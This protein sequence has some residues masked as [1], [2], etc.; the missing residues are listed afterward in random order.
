MTAKEFLNRP[1][2]LNQRIKDK[3]ENAERLRQELYGRGI[4]YDNTSHSP[5]SS[6]DALG[7][8]VAR[9]VDFEKEADEMID[10]LVALKIEVEHQIA[11]LDDR[12][13]RR[14]LEERYLFFAS[15]DKIAAELGYSKKHIY[16]LHDEAV[17]ALDEKL[18]QIATECPLTVS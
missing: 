17:N 16:R 4:S 6:M 8:A 15:F 10:Q 7:R 18:R 11:V 5:N 14:I 2:E 1:W 3:L 12:R 13:Y 9:V